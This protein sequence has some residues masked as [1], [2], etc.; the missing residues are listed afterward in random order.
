MT[1]ALPRDYAGV[2]LACPISFGYAR[3]T[4]RGVHWFLGQTLAALL[5]DAGL[6][7]PDV[8]GLA[9]ASYGL[10][11][12][13][14]VA[15]AEHLGMELGWCLDLPLGG[16]SAILAVQR[17][18]RA[19]Q[20]G[21]AE[22][23]ACLAAD[24]MGDGAFAGLVGGFSS[25]SRDAVLPY[26]AGGPNQVFALITAHYM[27][28]TGTRREDFGAL[29]LAQRRYGQANP[30]ALL[31][32]RLSLEQYLKARPIAPPLGLYD[33]VMPCC[34]A[35]GF[36]VMSED[37]ARSLA[38]PFVRL[39]GAVERHHSFADDP[40]QRLGGWAATRE[41]LY[42]QAGVAPADIDVLQA[43]D[44]YP[45]VVFMQLE[46][47]GFCEPGMAAA[48]VNERGV[49]IGQALPLNTNGGQLSVGQAG[50][51]GGFLGLTETLRQLTGRALGLAV[52]DAHVGLVS[53]YG[54]VTYDRGLCSAAA[55]LRA[56]A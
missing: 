50:A 36:L 6:A 29:C 40:V 37:R 17:A 42:A 31:R 46:E 49:G 32:G 26:G 27:A 44:D 10:A 1:D 53:G 25:F 20:A 16:A 9:V 30:A 5:A 47:L 21:D 18:A 56:A 43:Y 2:V 13:H 33:C 41:R 22:I 19:V 23:I 34:G 11:P 7:K 3:G 35:E 54:T 15:L 28:E 45:V 4:R 39:A 55:I 48:F 24:V 12:D 38:I 51:A 52:E 8:D 14:S